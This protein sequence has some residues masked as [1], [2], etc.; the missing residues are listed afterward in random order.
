[1][2]SISNKHLDLFS[3]NENKTK[4]QTDYFISNSNFVHNVWGNTDILRFIESMPDPFY[5]TKGERM[6]YSSF[7]LKF[8]M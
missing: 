5:A 4:Q 3:T 7:L 2:Y 6:L 1:M 8:Q